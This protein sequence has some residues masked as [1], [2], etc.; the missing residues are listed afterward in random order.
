MQPY[1]TKAEVYAAADAVNAKGKMP[2]ADTVHAVI[3]EANDQFKAAMKK[4]A[5]AKGR[6][7]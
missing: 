2:S 6:E 1:V 3:G 7:G 5:D 4:E